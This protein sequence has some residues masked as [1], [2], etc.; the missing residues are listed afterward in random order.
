MLSKIFFF[1]NDVKLYFNKLNRKY[2]VLIVICIDLVFFVFSVWLS[3]FL[4]YEKNPDLNYS[5]LFFT[6]ISIIIAFPIFWVCRLYN[7]I[8]KYFG[9][10]GLNDLYKATLIYFL[11]NLLIIATLKYTNYSLNFLV[12]H[13]ILFVIM[14]SSIRMY[15]KFFFYNYLKLTALKIVMIYG[16]GIAGR[17]LAAALQDND[18][19][20]VKGFFDDNGEMDGLRIF[21]NRI[22]NS[23][24]LQKV[25]I[26][27]KVTDIII[28]IPSITNEQKNMII[29]KLSSLKVNI[30]TLPNLNKI[31]TG[32][33]NVT[34]ILEINNDDL[35]Y[36]ETIKPNYSLIQTAVKKQVIVITGAGG[37]IGSEICRQLLNYEPKTLI[38]IDNSETLLFNIDNELKFIL[39]NYNP[40]YKINIIPIIASIC[41]DKR[42]NY[43][44]T[45]FKPNIIYHTAA[46]KHVPLLESN[47]IEG[48]RNNI[49]GTINLSEVAKKNNVNKF[50][51]VSTDKAVRPSNIMGATKRVCE[52]YLQS[53]DCKL[54]NT[55]K[56]KTKF[57][58]VRFGNVMNSSGSVIPLF[59]KQ[60]QLGGPIYLTHKD[61]ERYFMTIP[62]AAQL[63]IQSSNFAKGG[64]VFILGMGNRVKIY[65]L[66]IKMINLSGLSLKDK[67]NPNGDISIEYIGLRPGEKM[68]EELFINDKAEPTIHPKIIKATEKFPQYDLL[69]EEFK[70]LK[71]HFLANNVIDMVK[72]I[73]KMVEGYTPSKYITESENYNKI[74]KTK[75]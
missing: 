41:D 17:Q 46:Y 61:V 28:S 56:Y 23:N 5:F 53:L 54:K 64:E 58:I 8:I 39:K 18:K 50:I 44:V 73:E 25:V 65:D 71:H 34:D 35:L 38:L 30:Q 43:I 67:S 24:K 57:S 3:L 7:N 2:K 26:S 29:K 36:R 52:M 4:L 15:F 75:I 9:L 74:S 6:I 1:K 72:Q 10:D 63:V 14:A 19:Y 16:A 37:S 66:A 45:K 48:V 69:M 47:P 13:S 60:I 42:M 32:E 20:K 40:K 11:S 70:V 55:K 27:K 49:F 51:F 68:F 22:Y 31:I 33:K 12:Y 62:E 21:G 59:K